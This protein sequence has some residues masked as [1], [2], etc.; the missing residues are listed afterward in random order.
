[1]CKYY[2]DLI[3]Y[4][5]CSKTRIEYCDYASSLPLNQRED[6][7]CHIP[8]DDSDALIRATDPQHL[9]ALRQMR[10]VWQKLDNARRRLSDLHTNAIARQR[11]RISDLAS[12]LLYF[13]ELYRE[14]GCR[15]YA[16]CGWRAHMNP[17]VDPRTHHAIVEAL[18][19]DIPQGLRDFFQPWRDLDATIYIALRLLEDGS[20]GLTDRIQC[21]HEECEGAYILVRNIECSLGELKLHVERLERMEPIVDI[22]DDGTRVRSDSRDRKTAL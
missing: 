16:G 18:H 10:K 13:E 9:F 6:L 17:S 4:G 11:E 19:G 7:P 12:H 22:F 2:R 21:A 20:L 8:G 14:L 5:D 15:Y 3:Q 1:M